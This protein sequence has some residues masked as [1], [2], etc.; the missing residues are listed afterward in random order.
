MYKYTYTAHLA[1]FMNNTNTLTIQECK[2]YKTNKLCK[3]RI[4]D[5]SVISNATNL[6][7]IKHNKVMRDFFLLVVCVILFL[8]LGCD[9]TFLFWTEGYTN[10]FNYLSSR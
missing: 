1:F 9:N 5:K 2:Q 8:R 4:K 7:Y 10:L 3:S 6:V